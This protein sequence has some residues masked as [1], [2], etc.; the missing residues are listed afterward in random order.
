MSL[1][2]QLDMAGVMPTILRMEKRAEEIHN[3]RRE[4]LASDNRKA[5]RTDD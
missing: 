4:H 1:L 2:G 3:D 5:D